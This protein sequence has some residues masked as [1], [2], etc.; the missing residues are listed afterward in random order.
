[1]KSDVPVSYSTIRQSHPALFTRR[2]KVCDDYVSQCEPVGA[3]PTRWKHDVVF[4]FYKNKGA[5]LKFFSVKFS[6]NKNSKVIT[7]TG[8]VV[9]LLRALFWHLWCRIGSPAEQA[10]R[11]ISG[12]C[13]TFFWG[14]QYYNII[15]DEPTEHTVG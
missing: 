12:P 8:G 7:D 9:C 5:L 1:M 6:E 13:D 4:F 15:L 10:P 14:P 11:E 3:R 2:H